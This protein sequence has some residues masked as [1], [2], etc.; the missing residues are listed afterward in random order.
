[1]EHSMPEQLLLQEPPSEMD[2]LTRTLGLGLWNIQQARLDA[3]AFR[4]K[5]EDALSGMTSADSTVVVLGS[6]ARDEFTGGSDVDWT[7]LVDGIANPK[8]L[9]LAQGIRDI[10]QSLGAKQPGP[11]GIF[12]NMAFSHDIVHQIG[13]EDDTNSN[14]TRRICSC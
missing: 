4:L 3:R 10:L 14:T 6:L 11:E 13:G 2:R 1:M 5:F 12:G 8:H 9:D 7:L